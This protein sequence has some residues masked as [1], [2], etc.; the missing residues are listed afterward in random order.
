[1]KECRG[2]RASALVAALSTSDKK[3]GHRYGAAN[4]KP[5]S[6]HL[7]LAFIARVAFASDDEVAIDRDVIDL[8]HR[9][10]ASRKQESIA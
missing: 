1:M 9:W 4:S 3:P 5:P 10:P 6:F 8:S 7:E 2:T